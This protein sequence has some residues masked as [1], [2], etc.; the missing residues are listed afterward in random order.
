MAA[1]RPPYRVP[2]QVPETTWLTRHDWRSHVTTLRDELDALPPALRERLRARGFEPE[3]LRRWAAGLGAGPDDKNRLRGTVEPPRAG[4]VRDIAPD[5]ARAFAERGREAVARG[6]LAVCVLAG[7]MATR[8][9]GVVKALVEL[10]PG[11]TFLELR[12]GEQRALQE[13][14]G[15]R[16]PLWLMTSEPTEP[17]I[18]ER[19]GAARD[20]YELATFE[21]FVSLR[22][23]PGGGLFRDEHGE[24][25]VYATGHG[26]LP[27]ALRRSG[28]IARFLERG[29]RH[30]WIWNLDNIGARLDPAVLGF[31]LAHGGPLTVELVDKR[32]GDV[33]GGPVRHD[34]RP[35]ICE[36]F[37]LPRGFDAATVPVFNTNTF[38]V[39]AEA[40]AALAFDW[41]Y[42]EVHKDVGG[43]PAVQFER[44]LGELSVALP[45]SFL[46]VPRDG[47]E[48]RFV[49]V[50]DAADLA[51][52]QA[53]LELVR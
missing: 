53:F 21:Q 44:L 12:L 38:L 29:G 28:L 7:G 39:S 26:D 1:G 5:E 52:A 2:A 45:P 31:H 14:F 10:R 6:E 43:R 13:K 47:A 30:V 36:H 27:D 22:L 40:L 23:A 17:G 51:R 50:K 35:I 15:R 48:S 20:G 4:D 33:G 9:G 25:S 37:R 8:M 49:P 24:P 18:A 41:S 11:L 16:A 42:V 46:R 34:G 19:L 32:G 3:V